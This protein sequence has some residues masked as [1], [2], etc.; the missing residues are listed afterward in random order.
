MPI[1]F[2]FSPFAI[3]SSFLAPLLLTPFFSLRH[4]R[5][6]AVCLFDIFTIRHGFATLAALRHAVI[7]LRFLFYA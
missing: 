6:S 7:I 2:F 1:I 4:A 3:F 5:Q